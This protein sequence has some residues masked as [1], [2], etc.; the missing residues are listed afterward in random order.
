LEEKNFV[1]FEQPIVSLASGRFE[2]SELLL[3]MRGPGGEL[4]EPGRFLD[5]AERFGH[6]QAID[7]WVVCEAIALLAKR[8]RAGW[9]H[10]LEVNL[11]AASLADERVIE[12]IASMVGQADIDPA[13]LVFE[14]T[15]TAAIVDVERARRFASRLAGLGCQLALDDFGAEF[16]SFAQLKQLPFDCVKIDGELITNLSSNPSNQLTVQAIVGIAR[17][18]GKETTA[19][20]VAD[21]RTMDL[22]HD[23]GVD[24]AQG[25]HVGRPGPIVALC[26]T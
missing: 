26:P 15:E 22:L 25:Y 20:F 13:K 17:S 21:E 16:G 6:V 11:S 12:H 4:V 19:E 8:Q 10:H 23:Y 14:I 9:D 2:R 7:S 3:R 1:L 24:H 5:D 18:L